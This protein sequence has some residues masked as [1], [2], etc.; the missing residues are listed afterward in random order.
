MGIFSLFSGVFS[1]LKFRK[2]IQTFKTNFP[3]ASQTSTMNFI[4]I[5]RAGKEIAKYHDFD[6]FPPESIR[7]KFSSA[8]KKVFLAYEKRFENDSP[9]D[10]YHTIREVEQQYGRKF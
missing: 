3:D 8:E 1:D 2:D 5:T 10:M 4:D 6:E 9:P 7:K